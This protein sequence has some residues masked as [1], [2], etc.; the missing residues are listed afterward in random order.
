MFLYS[1]PFSLDPFLHILNFSLSTGTYPRLWKHSIVIPIPKQSGSSP[2]NSLRPISLI[3]FLSKV[4]EK[5]CFDQLCQYFNQIRAIPKFQSGFRSGHSSTTALL[6]LSNLVLQAMDRRNI[7]CIV[8]LDFSKAF[9]TLDHRLLVA[10]LYGFGIKDTALSWLSSYLSDRSQEV[11]VSE[12][13]PA[14]SSSRSVTRGVPQGSVLGPLLFSIYVADLAKCSEHCA[15][16][17]YADDVLIVKTFK[18]TDY[19]STLLQ[20]ESDLHAIAR[21]TDTHGLSLNPSK[22]SLLLV[23]S[24][25]LLAQVNSFKVHFNAHVIYP[26][27]KLKNLGLIMD[28]NW[29]FEQHV[30]SKIR[31]AYFRLRKLYAIARVLSRKQKLILASILVIS[32]FDYADIVYYPCLTKRVSL[33]IQR[34]QNACVRFA[35]GLRKFDHLTPAFIE[36]GWLNMKQRYMVHLCCLIYKLISTGVPPYLRELLVTNH[37]RRTDDYISTRY[38]Y[39][40]SVPPC[41]STKFY[42][43][44]TYCSA[45]YYNSLPSEIRAVTSFA[46]FKHAATLFFAN[47]Q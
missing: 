6:H 35:F 29:T 17:I 22:T 20:V 4:F 19:S 8:S 18:P 11:M 40:L 37:E 33:R 46:S 25:P 5:L 26:Q 47:Q 44:F 31:I 10:V 32:L 42:S 36:S 3:P 12:T 34:V 9:D 23:G 38:D 43:S 45:L 14:F 28:P 15:S 39:N 21:W 27:T 16:Y 41:H 1:I 24:N 30:N 13:L 7:A 2:L